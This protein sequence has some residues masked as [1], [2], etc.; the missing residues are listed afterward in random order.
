[1]QGAHF[2]GVRVSWFLARGW[3]IVADR[4]F[5]PFFPRRENL[6]FFSTSIYILPVPGIFW[7]PFLPCSSWGWRRFCVFFCERVMAVV[8]L[9]GYSN[10]FFSLC[11]GS[12]SFFFGFCDRAISFFFFEEN[13]SFVVTARSGLLC[14]NTIMNID[15]DSFP[16]LSFRFSFTWIGRRT[17][18]PLSRCANTESNGDT[19]P[20][21]HFFWLIFALDAGKR[22]SL[23]CRMTCGDVWLRLTRFEGCL[24]FLI[25][26]DL[27]RRY[28]SRDTGPN[29]M[30][31][32]LE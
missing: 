13:L 15:M 10:E 3:P 18:R 4:S 32:V 9:A 24:P 28:D 30:F 26:S 6:F 22:T 16:L 14:M 5:P 20:L 17:F 7:F 25:W 1:M 31:I 11:S 21:S 29:P 19:I 8:F 27:I 2:S 12:F 23:E